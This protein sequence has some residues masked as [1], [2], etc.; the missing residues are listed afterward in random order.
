MT[1]GTI[2]A[3]P[4]QKCRSFRWKCGC[5]G[6]EIAWC[7]LRRTTWHAVTWVWTTASRRLPQT[8]KKLRS[9]SG[10][11]HVSGRSFSLI[12]Q[13]PRGPY[14]P[15]HLRWHTIRSLARLQPPIPPLLLNR[16]GNRSNV[17]SRCAT[18]RSL[19]SNGTMC[20]T[21]RIR[22]RPCRRSC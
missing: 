7:L 10:C 15:Y 9:H 2:P 4:M 18:L 16:C 19:P 22:G 21:G 5:S 1:G 17:R 6:L 11:L 8:G 14:R 13:Q 3:R 20:S 12:C